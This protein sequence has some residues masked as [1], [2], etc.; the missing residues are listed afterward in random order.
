MIR[1]IVVHDNCADGLASAMI[2]RLKFP[3]AAIVFLNY[4]T[5]ELAAFQPGPGQLWCD[6]SPPP[7]RAQAFA[8]AGAYI[9]DHHKTARDVVA[10][11]GERGMFGDESTE[12]GVSGAVLAA[13]HVL[14]GYP[15]RGMSLSA[16][17]NQVIDFARLVGIRDTW[18]KDHPDWQEACEL[19][20]AL[21]FWPRETW[22]QAAPS[23]WP[24]LAEIGPVLI[25]R[26]AA[27]CQQTI[28]R[29]FR[30]TVEG[31]RV[32]LF[33]GGSSVTSDSA[34]IVG[35]A[36]DLVVGFGY[37][38]EG[39]VPSVLYSLRSRTGF[40][41]GAMGKNF[42]GGGHSGAGGFKRRVWSDPYGQFLGLLKTYLEDTR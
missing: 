10:M 3:E 8:D 11:F 35:D 25:Q 20:E 13:R 32:V 4:N 7:E 2:L 39:D 17:A 27:E 37:G 26:H 14:Y 28:K 16:L 30:D 42:G 12:P 1:Q 34:E 9:L 29:A 36:A 18:Q 40:D 38:V 22:L 5:P 31:I 33:Q 19:S 24:R 41:C 15:A 21:R 23:E 6:F